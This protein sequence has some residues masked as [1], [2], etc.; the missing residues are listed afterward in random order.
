MA[1]RRAA[2]K[3]LTPPNR[4][5]IRYAEE[6]VII[7]MGAAGA[8]KTTIGRA[9]AAELGWSFVDGNAH[10]PAVDTLHT[11]VARALDRREPT[12]IAC[13][14]LR[15]RYREILRGDRHPVRFVYLQAGEPELQR[16]LAGRSE[17][18][19]G[20]SLLQSQLAALEAPAAD[21]ALTVDASWPPERILGAIRTEFGV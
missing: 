3:S 21:E 19:A 20:P 9:L 2:A 5:A 15:R 13:S 17:A 10:H 11:I 1:G 7:L 14:A 18:V 4:H 12:V 16:R 8:G 6:V